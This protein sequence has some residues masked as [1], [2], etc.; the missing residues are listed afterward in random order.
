VRVATS[1]TRVPKR[2]PSRMDLPVATPGQQDHAPAPPGPNAPC[3]SGPVP[4]Q[5]VSANIARPFPSPATGTEPAGSFLCRGI[6][7]RLR[8]FGCVVL[9]PATASASVVGAVSSA[10][11][12]S[13]P[14]G[15]R[16]SPPSAD[17]S[18]SA[19]CGSPCGLSTASG[20]LSTSV[21]PLSS[22]RINCPARCCNI[23]RRA[24]GDFQ[25]TQALD[26]GLHGR[27]RRCP[28]APAAL[29]PAPHRARRDRPGH[30]R[31]RRACRTPRGPADAPSEARGRGSAAQIRAFGGGPRR[32]AAAS[33]SSAWRPRPAARSASRTAPSGVGGAI[34]SSAATR[35][36]GSSASSAAIRESPK[37]CGRGASVCARG[38]R[39]R[40]HRRPRH[41][42]IKNGQP[43][44]FAEER[45]KPVAPDLFVTSSMKLSVFAMPA[46]SPY[47]H[48]NALIARDGD[49]GRKHCGAEK[50]AV[51]EK[52]PTE[53][54][55]S[56]LYPT[57]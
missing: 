6:G 1:G 49:R 45:E 39:N 34:A 37:A 27:P 17:S 41:D 52:Q 4:F 36:S 16:S 57:G 47:L 15:R 33:R 35:A 48:S 31:T 30:A 11:L 21:A 55:G 26:P 42:Q 56:I 22:A 54:I 24:G 5:R 43:R 44:P 7:R 50:R 32:A 9:C 3:R 20:A 29:R 10:V 23:R 12:P 25:P 40:P 53:P 28:E 46:R 8:R 13:A 14:G 19:P 18:A 51:A 38:I 2:S